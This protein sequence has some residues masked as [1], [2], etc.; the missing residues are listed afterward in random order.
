MQQYEL[1]NRCKQEK[2]RQANF[3]TAYRVIPLYSIYG[4]EAQIR[5]LYTSSIFML[6]QSEVKKIMYCSTSLCSPLKEGGYEYNVDEYEGGG[7]S[8]HSVSFKKD[9]FTISC[10]CALYEN[11]GIFCAHSLFVLMENDIYEIQSK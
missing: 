6:F 1:E 4:F 8:N 2:Y 10:D 5:D 9:P 7:Y 3:V 11:N